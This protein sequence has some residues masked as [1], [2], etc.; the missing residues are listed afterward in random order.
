M[1]HPL[2]TSVRMNVVLIC[3]LFKFISF[4]VAYSDYY[5]YAVFLI[6]KAKVKQFHYRPG[7]TQRFPGV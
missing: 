5:L 6:V 3:L 7:R 1:I 4:Y 2:K